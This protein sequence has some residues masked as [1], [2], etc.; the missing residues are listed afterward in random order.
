[1]PATS[2]QPMDAIDPTLETDPDINMAIDTDANPE[3]PGPDAS[4]LPIE[5]RI[6]TRKDISLRDFLGKMDD[7]API[8]R[9]SCITI[10]CSLWLS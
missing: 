8:V 4:E 1:M 2:L 9:Q 3:P 7:Y 5:P 6:A 10:T